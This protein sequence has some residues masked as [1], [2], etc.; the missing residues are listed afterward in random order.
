MHKRQQHP[1]IVRTV[2]AVS[3]T[4]SLS[5]GPNDTGFSQIKRIQNLVGG[6][7]Q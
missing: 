1:E 7:L 4:G 6:L 2:V 3:K 5:R